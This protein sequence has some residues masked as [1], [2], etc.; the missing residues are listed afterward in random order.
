MIGSFLKAFL[1]TNIIFAYLGQI[2]CALAQPL[3]L[4][5]TSKIASTWFRPERVYI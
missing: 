2:L 1:N 3:I 4:N 5:S